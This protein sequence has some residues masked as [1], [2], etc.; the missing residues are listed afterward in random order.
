MHINKIKLE[1]ITHCFGNTFETIRDKYNRIDD[2]GV[3]HGRAIYY[4]R[5]DDV[6]YKLFHK[7]YVRRTN[8]E[9]AIQKNFFDGLIP[10]L[11]ALIVDGDD[12]VGY[13][14]KA[15]KVLSDNES[16]FVLFHPIV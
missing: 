9:M 10:A 13:V 12:I 14:S 7:D 2:K 5:E 15:G 8:F 4:D 16:Y 6:Y 3:N 11:V 1:D